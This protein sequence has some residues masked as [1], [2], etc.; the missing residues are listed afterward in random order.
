MICFFYKNY[1]T[2]EF[3][4]SKIIKYYYISSSTIKLLIFILMMIYTLLPYPKKLNKKY[5]CTCHNYI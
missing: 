4:I 5:K 3:N 1:K 2:M